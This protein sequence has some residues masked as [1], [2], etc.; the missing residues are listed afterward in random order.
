MFARVFSGSR[1]DFSGE[2]IHDRSILIC[3]P[4]RAVELQRARP[5]TL[6]TAE[7]VRAI[8]EPRSKPLESHRHFAQP[9]SELFNHLVDHAAAH[10]CLADCYIRHPFGTVREQVADNY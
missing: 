2:Q 9:P 7:T 4:N 5:G 3:G 6:L 10:K 8:Q 1:G